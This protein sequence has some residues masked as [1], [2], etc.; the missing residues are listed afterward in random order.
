MS[1]SVAVHHFVA[2]LTTRQYGSHP[3]SDLLGVDYTY[4]VPADTE[5]PRRLARIDLFTRF[6][7]DRAGPTDFYVLVRWTDSPDDQRRRVG[8][9]GPYTVAFRPTDVV[10]DQVFRVQNIQL[11]GIGRYEILLLRRRSPDWKGR[12][13]GIL[14]Q[15]HFLVER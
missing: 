12:K 14:K 5:F 3:T 7:L 8:R 15:T 10:R 6:Y 9:Y 1:R 4:D 11:P 13:Y 2:N